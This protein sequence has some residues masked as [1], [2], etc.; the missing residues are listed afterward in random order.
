MHQIDDLYLCENCF[1]M[2]EPGEK[3]CSVCGFEKENY[4]PETEEL[5]VGEILAGKYLIGKMLGRGG[6]GFT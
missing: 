2:M 3:R 6:F 5:A 1:S 4:Q